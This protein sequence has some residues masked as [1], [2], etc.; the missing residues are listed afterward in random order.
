MSFFKNINI[1]I[2]DRPADS[3]VKVGDA[4]KTTYVRIIESNHKMTIHESPC[5]TIEAI[6]ELC[7]RHNAFPQFEKEGIYIQKLR[8]AYEDVPF[9]Y[10]RIS[11]ISPSKY[12]AKYADTY[13]P[14]GQVIYKTTFDRRE[15]KY[16]RFYK[17]E[18]VVNHPDAAHLKKPD[19]IIRHACRDCAFYGRCRNAPDCHI[20]NININNDPSTL[21][22]AVY[23]K[24]DEKN[25]KMIHSTTTPREDVRTTYI[26]RDEWFESL[27]VNERNEVLENK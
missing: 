15:E 5:T 8:D 24:Y 16:E 21:I 10:T 27:S 12:S 25:D 3:E 6:N 26:D 13:I 7:T 2:E 1:T 14:Y 19:T 4:G 9:H 22:D 18:K 17:V 11:P 23:F 20:K